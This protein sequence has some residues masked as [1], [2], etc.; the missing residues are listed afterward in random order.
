MRGWGC[1]E[2]HRAGLSFPSSTLFSPILGKAKFK[3]LPL[4]AALYQERAV[5]STSLLLGLTEEKK[6]KQENQKNQKKTL[7]GGFKPSCSLWQHPISSGST[8]SKSTAF[9]VISSCTTRCLIPA[10]LVAARGI[11][12]TTSPSALAVADVVPAVQVQVGPSVP[13]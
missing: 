10:T 4:S 3:T 12:S 13:T 5:L 2:D 1:R 7:S 8:R 9:K 11:Y 6:K